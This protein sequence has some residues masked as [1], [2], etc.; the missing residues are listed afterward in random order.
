MKTW[1][2]KVE[3]IRPDRAYNIDSKWFDQLVQ[4][5]YDLI[6]ILG[7]TFRLTSTLDD[8][9]DYG[10]YEAEDTDYEFISLRTSRMEKS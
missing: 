6:V 9:L 7:P 2:W 10:H 3:G 4:Q 5:G 8:W 1:F